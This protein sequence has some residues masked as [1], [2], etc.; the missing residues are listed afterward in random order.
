MNRSFFIFNPNYDDKDALKMKQ[1]VEN[2]IED[3]GDTWDDEHNI[4]I[5][6]YNKN[7]GTYHLDT[8]KIEV[9]LN[10][11]F[12]AFIVC[13]SNI[14]NQKFYSA[15]NYLIVPLFER[16]IAIV[17]QNQ[18]TNTIKTPNMKTIDINNFDGPFLASL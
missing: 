1:I 18:L 14:T 2:I 4:N 9:F 17:Y 8:K 10:K 6:N 12:D 7:G 11:K 5:K 13:W 16:S 15:T 3:N